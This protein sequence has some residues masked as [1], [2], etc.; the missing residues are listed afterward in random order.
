MEKALLNIAKP[1]S[2]EVRIVKALFVRL[3]RAADQGS[4][5]NPLTRVT[6]SLF[7]QLLTVSPLNQM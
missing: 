1:C 2:I 6:G 3:H 7:L 4:R 5:V